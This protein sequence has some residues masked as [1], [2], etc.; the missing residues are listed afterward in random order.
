MT[1]PASSLT[2]HVQA[3]DVGA[4]VTAA[5][6]IGDAPAFA[7]GDGA[8]LL[9]AGRQTPRPRAS[10]RLHSCRRRRRQDADHRR[11]R[12]PRGR[13][14]GGWRDA[15]EIAHEKGRWIDALAG[16]RRAVAWAAGRDV[17]ARDS[18]GA[19]KTLAA[20]TTA[21]GLS[22]LPKGYRLAIA[23]YNGVSLW[24]PNVAGAA[25]IARMEGLAS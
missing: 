14:R 13:D 22:F 5:G 18:A 21:R 10:R 3:F 16:A 9:Q 23:H 17:R 19:I 7:L 25:L 12:R 24:F 8:V 15:R 20:A 11:R 4:H 1:E 6:F 2:R